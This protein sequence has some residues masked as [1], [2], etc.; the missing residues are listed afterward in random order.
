VVAHI[1]RGLAEHLSKDGEMWEIVGLCHDLDF[2]E[3]AADRT[4]HGLL[5][6]LWLRDRLPDA[7]RQAIAA[8]DHRTGVKA[9]TL[10]AD[11]L[12]AADAA[13]VIDERLGRGVW[14][15]LDGSDHT[16]SLRRRLSERAYLADILHT[17]ASRHAL[18]FARIVELM[19][20]AP[21]HAGV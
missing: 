17:N 2:F 7:A 11:M 21:Q 19:G 14:H 12:K 8:H 20:S 16:A 6:G 1:M 5:V 4:K 18:P 15:E 3:T 13:A 9:D 10:L